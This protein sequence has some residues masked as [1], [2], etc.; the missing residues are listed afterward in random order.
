[1]LCFRSTVSE[2]I[3]FSCLS[4]SNY[5]HYTLHILFII[6]PALFSAILMAVFH[7]I[8]DALQV[9]MEFLFIQLENNFMKYYFL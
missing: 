8:T 4:E 6:F 1:M 2:T 3:I 9:I 7:N 5:L